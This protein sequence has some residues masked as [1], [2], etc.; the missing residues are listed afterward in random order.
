MDERQASKLRSF[1]SEHSLFSDLGMTMAYNGKGGHWGFLADVVSLDCGVVLVLRV[2][3][4]IAVS[5]RKL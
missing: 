4:N 5:V 2:L 1:I 3:P